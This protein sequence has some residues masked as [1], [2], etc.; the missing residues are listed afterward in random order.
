[1]KYCIRVNIYRNFKCPFIFI[2]WELFGHKEE[3]PFKLTYTKEKGNLLKEVI[4]SNVR[5]EII[6]YFHIG[7]RKDSQEPI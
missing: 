7:T 2:F 6:F 3:K 1:M 4:E 5:Y